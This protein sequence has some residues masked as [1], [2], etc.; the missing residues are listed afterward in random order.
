MDALT[1]EELK[2]LDELINEMDDTYKG[3]ESFASVL[4]TTAMRACQDTNPAFQHELRQP[5]T[6]FPFSHFHRAVQKIEK[7]KQCCR[8]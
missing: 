3:N 2:T 8:Y 7:I 1:R 5:Q 4:C 6:P